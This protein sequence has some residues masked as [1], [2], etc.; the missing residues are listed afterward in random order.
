MEPRRDFIEN[1]NFEKEKKLT[2]KTLENQGFM[3]FVNLST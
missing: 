1:V 2:H 3:A